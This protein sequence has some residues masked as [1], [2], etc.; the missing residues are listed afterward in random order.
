MMFALRAWA[1]LV[2]GI[3]GSCGAA[4]AP[5][6]TITMS[7]IR[8]KEAETTR[9]DRT[10]GGQMAGGATCPQTRADTENPAEEVDIDLTAP[11]TQKA[12]LA[13]QSRFRRGHKKKDQ[14]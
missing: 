3:L 7:E 10:A 2:P 14:Q 11:E 8:R 13:I 4:H 1:E 5:A 12:A 6:L 9:E